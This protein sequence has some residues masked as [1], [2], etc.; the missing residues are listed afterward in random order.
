MVGAAAGRW[1]SVRMGARWS[2]ATLLGLELVLLAT[3]AV[4]L[5]L[6]GGR[7]PF[8]TTVAR[9][10]ALA[11]AA[12]AM[13]LQ[14]DV[15]R[16]V[17]GVSLSTTY[18]TGAIA[19]IGETIGTRHGD[20][21]RRSGRPLLAILSVVLIGYVGGAALGASRLGEGRTGLLVPVVLVAC[22]FAVAS[23]RPWS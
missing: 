12:L 13:G 2:A 6:A 21:D 11:V 18:Q 3:L 4:G 10:S 16:T 15:I 19:R 7:E 8:T 1:L 14:T 5:A 23:A 9:C 17:A 22:L 20:G